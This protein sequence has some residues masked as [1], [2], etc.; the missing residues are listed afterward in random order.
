MQG[1]DFVG[2]PFISSL[3]CFYTFFFLSY[4]V[5]WLVLFFLALPCHS[6]YKAA[7][8]EGNTKRYQTVTLP[9]CSVVCL[10]QT[11]SLYIAFPGRPSSKLNTCTY[12]VSIS[13]IIQRLIAGRDLDM[14]LQKYASLQ[15]CVPVSFPT[16]DG[17]GM[18]YVCAC[19]YVQ[20]MAST[21]TDCCR[22]GC[23]QLV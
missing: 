9:H 14:C 12:M 6:N 18:N 20:Q 22:C 17:L 21:A 1:W 16:A 10:D 3:S 13:F 7:N 8:L 5:T 4:N 23:E 2:L 15:R 19:V 11:Q